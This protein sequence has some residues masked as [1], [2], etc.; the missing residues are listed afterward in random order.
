MLVNAKCERSTDPNKE[1]AARCLLGPAAL[2]STSKGD[3]V[4]FVVPDDRPFSSSILF[5]LEQVVV[6][7]FVD[8]PHDLRRVEVDEA[9]EFLNAAGVV[10]GDDFQ[11]FETRAAEDPATRFE[12]LD[13]ELWVVRR[14]VL[15]GI[16][17]FKPV[18][19]AATVGRATRLRKIPHELVVPRNSNNRR[20]TSPEA[21]KN[22]DLLGVFTSVSGGRETPTR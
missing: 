22:F 9:C 4:D 2:S 20:Q 1:P 10:F 8:V 13:G 11:E 17:G 15:T 3:G 14:D 21:G 19:E 18:F 16:S 5:E 6:C 12:V 7:E